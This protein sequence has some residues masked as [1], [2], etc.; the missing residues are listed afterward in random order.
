ML[1]SVLFL[2]AL[3]LPEGLSAEDAAGACSVNVQTAVSGETS[4]AAL[5][6]YEADTEEWSL[7]ELDGAPPSDEQ[8]AQ[9]KAG[10]RGPLQNNYPTTV[11]LA[12]ALALEPLG[13]RDG[14]S[15]YRAD[16]LPEGTIQVEGRDISKHTALEIEVVEDAFGPMIRRQRMYAPKPF[17]MA[18]VARVMASEYL[19][20]YD[21]MP[22]GS[23]ITKSTLTA[24]E[25]K[26]MGRDRS[27]R[28]ETVFSGY[29]CG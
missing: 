6:R 12:E 21:R 11:A 14:A 1:L 9:F 18:M 23:I 20:D 17:R 5:Y 24:S 15:V 22:D 10:E 19:T 13:E 2:L 29:D 16:R 3:D 26:M 28:A 4:Q 25:F 27:I 7:L 8:M